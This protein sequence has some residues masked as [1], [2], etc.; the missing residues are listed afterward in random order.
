VRIIPNYFFFFF[1]LVFNFRSS[2]LGWNF[3]AES[4]YA[5]LQSTWNLA[6]NSGNKN[7]THVLALT[8]PE[9]RDQTTS[10]V[11]RRDELNANIL[12]HKQ[13]RL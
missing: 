5:A 4:T 1:F 2:D 9:C 10:L 8:V 7:R 13:E 3:D 12:A 6:L 11:R